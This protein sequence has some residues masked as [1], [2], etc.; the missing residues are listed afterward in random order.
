MSVDRKDHP[1]HLQQ[2]PALSLSRGHGEATPELQLWALSDWLLAISQCL[3][4]ARHPADLQSHTQGQYYPCD[5]PIFL[6]V[7]GL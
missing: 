2:Y 5:F 1:D 6:S 7:L 4:Q 3:E